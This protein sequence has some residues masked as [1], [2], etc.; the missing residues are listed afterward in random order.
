MKKPYEFA[1]RHERD[2]EHDTGRAHRSQAGGVEDELGD[3]DRTVSAL[4]VAEDRIVG[5]DVE[6]RP[7][8]DLATGF[9][10]G[11]RTSASDPTQYRS[12]PV[13]C[14]WW[15]RHG[16]R[17]RGCDRVDVGCGILR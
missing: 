16:R 10:N 6:R 13:G 17:R 12:A 8:V 11:H 7:R 3:V 4:A 14:G 9:R 2:D 5:G 15:R 1:R